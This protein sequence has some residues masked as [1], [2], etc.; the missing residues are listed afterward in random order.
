MVKIAKRVFA[1]L[2]WFL[3]LS[4]D[5]FWFWQCIYMTLACGFLIFSASEA[6]RVLE[7]G[8]LLMYR[9]F[10]FVEF[11]LF[12]NLSFERLNLLSCCSTRCRSCCLNSSIFFSFPSSLCLRDLNHLDTVLPVIFDFSK[13]FQNFD[14][15][16]SFQQS[17]FNHS[18]NFCCVFR[19]KLFCIVLNSMTARCAVVLPP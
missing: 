19:D 8:N 13:T 16:F 1:F 17:N 15:H 9:F 2:V 10:S 14:S 5:F 7:Y 3:I 12:T 18:V 4:K 6:A 11:N